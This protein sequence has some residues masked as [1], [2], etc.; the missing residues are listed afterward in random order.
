[1]KY[2]FDAAIFLK[3]MSLYFFLS[4]SLFLP[5]IFGTFFELFAKSVHIFFEGNA[6]YTYSFKW[7]GKIPVANVSGDS[8]AYCTYDSNMNVLAVFLDGSAGRTSWGDKLFD[9]TRPEWVER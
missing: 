8:F 7:R 6:D 9:I 2:R 4:Y 5:K 1:M 3:T